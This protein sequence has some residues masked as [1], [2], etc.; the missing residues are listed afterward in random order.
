M[1]TARAINNQ[2]YILHEHRALMLRLKWDSSE[3]DLRQTSMARR[4]KAGMAMCRNHAGRQIRMR[5][6]ILRDDCNLRL[7]G[8]AWNPRQDRGICL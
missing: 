2:P 1:L 6:P 7:E 8:P 4:N 3:M 5:G